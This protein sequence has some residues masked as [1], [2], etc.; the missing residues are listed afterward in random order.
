ML[1]PTWG[2]WAKNIAKVLRLN[3]HHCFF[4][5]FFSLSKPSCAYRHAVQLL[6]PASIVAKMNGRDSICKV[7]PCKSQTIEQSINE[8]YGCLSL[9]FFLSFDRLI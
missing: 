3:Q 7:L 8:C 6:S 5:R 2:H 9:V 4:A 1:G